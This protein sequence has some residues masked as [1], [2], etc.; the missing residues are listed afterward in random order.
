VLTYYKLYI[1]LW[2]NNC[3]R[4]TQDTHFQQ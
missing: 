2:G 4:C 1:F 3:C